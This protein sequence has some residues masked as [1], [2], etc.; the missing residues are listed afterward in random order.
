VAAPTFTRAAPEDVD[1]LLELERR[2]FPQ[3]WGRDAIAGEILARGGT[4]LVLRGADAAGGLTACLFFRLIDDEAHL[5]RVAV[6]PEHRRRGLGAEL[7]GEFIRRARGQGARAA[8]LEV[9]AGNTAALALYRKFGFQ[10]VGTRRGYYNGG[11]E[12]AVILNLN[13]NE[14]E[15]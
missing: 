13:L 12:D 11:R 1:G 9:G 4:G 10:T 15:P 3:P 8:V 7:M 5:F 6:A 2:C 14:E